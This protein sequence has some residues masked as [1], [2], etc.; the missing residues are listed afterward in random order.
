LQ[1]NKDEQEALK[2]AQKKWFDPHHSHPN[3]KEDPYNKCLIG[4]V[5]PMNSN[6]FGQLFKKNSCSFWEPF[7]DVLEVSKENL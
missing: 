3:E 4:D 5:N 6:K 1:E 7:F 2:I